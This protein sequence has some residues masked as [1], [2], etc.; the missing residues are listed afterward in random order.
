MTYDP[1]DEM[2][3]DDEEIALFYETGEQVEEGDYVYDRRYDID[4]IVDGIDLET[5]EV[6]LLYKH[7]SSSCQPESLT[8]E[9]RGE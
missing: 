3:V 4:A 7:G 5:G 6:S 9:G 8:F 2:A 1:E